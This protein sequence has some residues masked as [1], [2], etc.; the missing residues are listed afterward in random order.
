LFTCFES[1]YFVVFLWFKIFMRIEKEDIGNRIRMVRENL[2]LGQEELGR[3]TKTSKQSVSSY[4]IGRSYPPLDFLAAL[5]AVGDITIDQIVT[6]ITPAVATD[7]SPPKSK[8]EIAATIEPGR[9]Q[10]NPNQMFSRRPVHPPH[11]QDEAVPMEDFIDESFSMSE[12]VTMTIEVLES[13]TVYRSAL[14]SNVRAFHQ[15]VK[16]EG[17]MKGVK[18]EVQKMRAEHRTEMEE[19]KEMIRALGG[20]LP[21]KR[22][23]A[24]N[25]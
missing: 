23:T 15:A 1:V 10:P 11:G 18:E 14:A 21:Q 24:A 5:A 2:K 9:K 3:L 16:M 19:L 17:E 7:F 25:A 13:K 8:G 20:A 22:D 4:E 12:M 6:G